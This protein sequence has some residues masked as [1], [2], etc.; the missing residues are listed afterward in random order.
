MGLLVIYC[1]RSVPVLQ[2]PYGLPEAVAIGLII[3]LHKLKHN[4]LLSIGGGTI[5]YML[6]VQ[7]VF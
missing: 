2:Q 6:L 1:L 3:L 4:M 7:L 5:C